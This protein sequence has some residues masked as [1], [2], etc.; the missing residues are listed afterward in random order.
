MWKSG[1][2]ECSLLLVCVY[3][4][5][6][7]CFVFS[8][9]F[10]FFL[11]CVSFC[12]FGMMSVLVAF[13]R[14]G[15]TKIATSQRIRFFPPVWFTRFSY[16]ITLIPVKR[17]EGRA[18]KERKESTL[19]PLF[20]S[21]CNF[22]P[23]LMM[24]L[25]STPFDLDS[26]SIIF[27]SPFILFLF[28]SL[29]FEIFLFLLQHVL[30]CVCVFSRH[31]F[32]WSFNRLSW[33][34]DD[35]PSEL[36]V[37]IFNVKRRVNNS[38]PLPIKR[39]VCLCIFYVRIWPVRPIVVIFISI[40]LARRKKN[41]KASRKLTLSFSFSLFFLLYLCT[42]RVKLKLSRSVEGRGRDGSVLVSDF[43]VSCT[44][45]EGKG[46]KQGGFIAFHLDLQANPSHL[47][48]SLTS[49]LTSCCCLF[50]TNRQFN[51]WSTCNTCRVQWRIISMT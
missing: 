33:R 20:F 7:F 11:F 39:N 5:C 50:M 46:K 6:G 32:L 38:C 40:H 48:S 18:I 16:Y 3:F 4:A 41:H 9:V 27:F 22:R 12:L 35:V 51:Q 24:K 13:A 44:A 21:Q 25:F 29:F 2:V 19:K 43:E 23:F 47:S 37:W 28:V 34:C 15:G 8:F 45:T 10:L 42:K 49:S 17:A 1:Y 31:L 14:V 36:L 26:R 30:Q